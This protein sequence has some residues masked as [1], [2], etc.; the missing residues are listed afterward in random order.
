MVLTFAICVICFVARVFVIF[1]GVYISGSYT[2]IYVLCV[3][4]IRLFVYILPVSFL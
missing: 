2:V 3:V 4:I 1:V